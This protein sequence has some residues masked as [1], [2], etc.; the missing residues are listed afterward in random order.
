MAHLAMREPE[1]VTAARLAEI[2]KV[3]APYLSKVLQQLR[4]HDL[5]LSQRGVGGGIRLAR[6]ASRITILDVANAVDPVQR[7]NSCPLGLPGHGS[8]LCPLHR[9]MDNALKQIETTFA[10][11]TLSELIQEN[12]GITPLCPVPGAGESLDDPNATP[13]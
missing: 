11:S 4:D 7:I 10:T 1:A 13:A 6:E 9:R 8:K 3:P 12:D 2:T 5:V